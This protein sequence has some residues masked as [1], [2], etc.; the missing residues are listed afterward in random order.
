M[1]KNIFAKMKK[2][3]GILSTILVLSF[4]AILVGVGAKGNVDE[5]DNNSSL[6]ASDDSNKIVRNASTPAWNNLMILRDIQVVNMGYTITIIL[7]GH[8]VVLMT[9][10]VVFQIQ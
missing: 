6:L 1:K 5:A 10:G 7:I 3:K 4:S 8:M 9:I 2:M